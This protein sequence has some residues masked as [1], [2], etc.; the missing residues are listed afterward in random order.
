MISVS[1]HTDPRS[2]RAFGVTCLCGARGNGQVE[3]RPW[4]SLGLEETGAPGEGAPAEDNPPGRPLPSL[5]VG[6]GAL[7]P[8]RT[9][10]LARRQVGAGIFEVR[11]RSRVD[12]PGGQ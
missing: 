8:A 1:V 12:H 4:M 7:V 3:L 9:A 10:P 6:G 11:E 2:L 5:A